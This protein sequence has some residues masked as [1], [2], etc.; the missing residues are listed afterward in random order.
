MAPQARL[1]LASALTHLH[2]GAGRA[3]GS[4]DLPVVR[5]PLGYPYLRGTMVKGSL[6]T[7]LAKRMGCRFD[8][9]G[10]IKCSTCSGLCCLLGGEVEE[11]EQGASSVGIQDFYPLLI[12]APAYPLDG[13]PSLGGVA[14]VTTAALASRAEALASAARLQD[15]ASALAGLGV[16]GGCKAVLYHTGGGG[17]GRVRLLV[18]GQ[19]VEACTAG[20]AGLSGALRALGELNPLYTRYPVDSRLLVFEDELGR[21]IVER[22]MERV[23]RVALDRTTKT[24]MEGHLWTE[25]YLPWGTLLVGFM[26]ETGFENRFCSARRA[27]GGRER[28]EGSEPL[29]ELVGMVRDELGSVLVVGG[30]ES[31]GAGVVKLAFPQ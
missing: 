4:V 13:G 6:K 25:E 31:V 20:P 19:L 5:D 12:P 8:D 10:R 17:E 24:V 29:E 27:A 11:G 1:V 14:Y 3:P 15:L 22:V 9:R 28:G 7:M 26:Y 30:K 2:P 16:P 18:A 23:T 21:M